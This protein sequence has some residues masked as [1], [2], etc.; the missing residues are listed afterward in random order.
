MDTKQLSPDPHLKS[1]DLPPII[2]IGIGSPGFTSIN[3]DLEDQGGDK[4]SLYCFADA[5]IVS[6]PA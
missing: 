3:C 1:F 6:L 5:P 4:P 2:G